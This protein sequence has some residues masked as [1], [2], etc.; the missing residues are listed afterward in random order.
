[1]DA[2]ADTLVRQPSCLHDLPVAWVVTVVYNS[3]PRSVLVPTDLALFI[4]LWRLRSFSAETAGHLHTALTSLAVAGE[5]CDGASA[6]CLRLP[7]DAGVRQVTG[8]LCAWEEDGLVLQRH[9]QCQANAGRPLL[10][11]VVEQARLSN[12]GQGCVDTVTEDCLCEW[13]P[14]RWVQLSSRGQVHVDV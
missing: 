2:Q 10:L 14:V 3:V 12:N 1:M 13:S 5:A 8:A 6:P 11:A 7:G 4:A 9:M